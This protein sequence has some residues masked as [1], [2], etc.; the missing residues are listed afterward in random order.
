MALPSKLPPEKVEQIL[1]LYA[2]LGSKRET[3]R[4]LGV[5]DVTVR[6]CVRATKALC[7]RCTASVPF[8]Q[9][10]CQACTAKRTERARER[11][12]ERRREGLCDQC[13]ERIQP[14]STIYCD[15]H[16]LA[17][18]ERSRQHVGNK[19]RQVTGHGLPTKREREKQIRYDYG[20]AGIE[21]WHRDKESCV[22]CGV[23]YKDKTIHIHH[24]DGNH[25]HNVKNNLTCLC[26]RCHK[27]IHLLS[28]HP[29]PPHILTWFVAHYPQHI[30]AHLIQR[31]QST[32][33]QRKRGTVTTEDQL[34][35]D[36][37]ASSPPAPFTA[38]PN[39]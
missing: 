29:N 28:Q 38:L 21:A 3:A 18:Q 11:R 39:W 35:L 24:L 32:R 23:H 13:D 33:R 22:L 20:Q 10:F 2:E 6:N 34:T 17:H 14:P 31:G 9:R 36:E 37:A 8:G 27:L 16:R 30:L 4:R 25:S 1:A 26:F 12:K 15:T 7:E 5:T 19:L